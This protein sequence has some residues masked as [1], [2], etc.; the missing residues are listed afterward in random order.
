MEALSLLF[1]VG[2]VNMVTLKLD[3][4]SRGGLSLVSNNFINQLHRIKTPIQNTK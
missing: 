4:E 1:D 3:F 2:F